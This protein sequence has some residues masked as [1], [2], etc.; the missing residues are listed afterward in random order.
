MSETQGT[1]E[2]DEVFEVFEEIEEDN[3]LSTHKVKQIIAE[4][5]ISRGLLFLCQKLKR[6][7]DKNQ[8]LSSTRTSGDVISFEHEVN[9]FKL[10]VIK[11][12]PNYLLV[13]N[14]ITFL[15]RNQILSECYKLCLVTSNCL[16]RLFLREVTTPLKW[17]DFTFCKIVNSNYF[18]VFPKICQIDSWFKDN[19]LFSLVDLVECESMI[20]F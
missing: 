12:D 11:N 2:I 16:K 10:E 5:L 4:L 18:L 20:L 7:E 19:S 13:S 1:Q 15:V 17:S 3:V 9:F 6:V 14:G 8:F